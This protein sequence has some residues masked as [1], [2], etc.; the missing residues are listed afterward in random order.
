MKPLL[1]KR[2]MI[3]RPEHQSSGLKSKLEEL[4]AEVFTVP[5]VQIIAPE[6]PL[7]FELALEN[8]SRYDWVVL[9][10]VNG[11]EAVRA[12]MEALSLSPESLKSRKLA[13]IGPATAQALESAFRAPDLVPGEY[14]SEAIAAAMP[15][16]HGLKFLL[17]RA[18]L[19]RKDLAD[20]LRTMG[21]EV[22]EVAAYRIVRSVNA[23]LPEEKPD[24]ITFT[25]AEIARATFDLL[26]RKGKAGWLCKAALIC[27]GPITAKA[28]REFGHEPAAVA[29]EYDEPGLRL[30]LQDAPA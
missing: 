24:A 1:G 5:V 4:G 8:L 27:I 22:D 19:A 7:P 15:D 16:V 25:S 2:V 6:D 23:D 13:A 17:A 28:V 12:Q 3:T 29:A 9:T 11:V 10:S 18:D 30:L 20:T 14:V 26:T 21:A